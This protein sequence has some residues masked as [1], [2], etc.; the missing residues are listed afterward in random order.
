[1]VLFLAAMATAFAAFAQDTSLLRHDARIGPESSVARRK[2]KARSRSTRARRKRSAAPHCLVRKRYG[3]KVN[4]LARRVR[5]Q[6]CSG[7]CRSGGQGHEVDAVHPP[8]LE[9]GDAAIGKNPASRHV[10]LLVPS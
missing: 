9:N 6:F 10:S 4:V 5:E 7:P 2:K 3:I 8:A 1:L